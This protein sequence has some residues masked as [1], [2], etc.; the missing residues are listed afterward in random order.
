MH[1]SGQLSDLDA[2][3]LQSG[4]EVSDNLGHEGLHRRD[5]DDLELIKVVAPLGSHLSQQLEA[6]KH[7]DVGLTCS[8]W[9]AHQKVL[10][11]LESCREEPGLDAIEVG[12]VRRK[13]GLRPL[14]K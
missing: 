2:I 12:H 4:L 8:R 10:R 14:W 3:R 11:R 9:S 6:R 5:V 1:I 7:R 13:S